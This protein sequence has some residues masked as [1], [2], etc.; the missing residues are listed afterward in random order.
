VFLPVTSLARLS[1]SDLESHIAN[2]ETWLAF[3]FIDLTDAVRERDRRGRGGY[4]L[5]PAAE[6]Y[7]AQ[8]QAA[9]GRALL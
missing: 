5:T 9:R 2:L 4:A 3:D 7:I 1:D 6:A 8:H